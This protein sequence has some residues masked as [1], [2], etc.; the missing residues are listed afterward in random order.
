MLKMNYWGMKWDLHLDICP[1]DAYF[2]EWVEANKL[3]GKTFYHFGTGTH[4]I[5]G[6]RQAEL[7]NAVFAITASK[8]EYD[9]YVA[10]VTENSPVAKSYLAYFGDI[11]L[12]NPR[13]L[14]DFD[15]VTLFHL[16]EFSQPNTASAE[17]G[18]INRPR[19]ARHDD[20][21]RPARAGILSSIP[22]RTAG[23]R[24]RPSCRTGKGS[25]RSSASTISR[26]C[27]SIARRV[28]T[29]NSD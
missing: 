22:S 27:G 23:R 15:A 16:Y 10:L 18:G 19:P 4:H 5:V 7:G 29:A 13:L 11:Y 6:L 21:P 14:P 8:E 24:R 3:T 1:C 25:S 17:Y 28:E 20:R 26:R 2:N 12:S 9:S